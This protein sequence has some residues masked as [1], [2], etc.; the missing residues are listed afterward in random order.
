MEQTICFHDGC[1]HWCS[2]RSPCRSWA[3]L[4]RLCLCRWRLARWLVHRPPT[5][6]RYLHVVSTGSAFINKPKVPP[7]ITILFIS[8]TSLW[9]DFCR[10]VKEK[11]QQNGNN[12]Y[13]VMLQKPD[14][15][16]KEHALYQEVGR[17]TIF[18]LESWWKA[19]F[20]SPALSEFLI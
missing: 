11:Y 16:W 8:T 12:I 20:K 2:G 14:S 7:W 1:T 19:S 3:Q 9:S 4:L 6:T 10:L 18:T 5:G 13:V 17:Q 15:N